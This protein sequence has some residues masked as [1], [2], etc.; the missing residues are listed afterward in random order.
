MMDARLKSKFTETYNTFLF[1][2][3][4][5]HH[6]LQNSSTYEMFS[7]EMAIKIHFRY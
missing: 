7:Y 5:K 4:E 2:N 3:I 1:N 6:S